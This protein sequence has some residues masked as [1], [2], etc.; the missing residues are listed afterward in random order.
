MMNY[1]KKS[2]FLSLLK[3]YS[4]RVYSRNQCFTQSTFSFTICVT[5]PKV[6]DAIQLPDTHTHTQIHKEMVGF[7]SIYAKLKKIYLIITN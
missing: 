2:L 3:F 6:I 1:K 7:F 5:I 4:E